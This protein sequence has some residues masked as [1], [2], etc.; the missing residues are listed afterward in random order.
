VGVHAQ[1]DSV[2]MANLYRKALTDGKCY[3]ALDYLSNKIGGRLS[4]SPQSYQAIHWAEKTMKEFGFD[5]VWLQPC[6]VPHWVRG[7]KEKGIAIIYKTNKNLEIPKKLETHICALGGSVATPKGGIMAPVVMVDSIQDLQKLGR[8]AIE[9][10]IVFFNRRMDEAQINTF[11]AYGRAVDQRWAG[12]S[13][14]ARYGAVATICRSME[15]GISKHPHTGSM[16]YIDSLPKI[17]CAAIST[18]DAEE[19]GKYIKEGMGVSFEIE[20]HCQTLADTLSYSVVGELK[21]TEHPEE[22]ILVGGHLD[23]W[24]NG[25]GA[26]DDGAGVVQSMEVLRLFKASGIKPKRTLRA[27]LF[28]NEENGLRGGKKYAELAKE[29]HEK[30]ICAIETDAGGHT[31]RGFG[32]TSDSAKYQKLLSWAPLFK[33]YHIYEFEP[34]GGGADIGPLK[35]QGVPLMAY[36][37]DSQRYFDYH[38]TEIDKF[39]NVNKRELEMGS[40]TMAI[41]VWLLSAHGWE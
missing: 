34:H 6:M 3:Q 33:P 17:P 10:K 5:S 41:F 22:I 19:L 27:V 16:R 28:M 18:Y 30:H 13:E 29:N 31:P 23:A 2:M 4:G 12:P 35:E 36:M 32:L 9:G 7:A 21:G 38:H 25:D 24:D 40:A 14:A 39:E 37:P 8:K 11:D 20:M 15:V 1:N 26:H